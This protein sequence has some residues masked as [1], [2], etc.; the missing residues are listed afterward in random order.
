MFIGHTCTSDILSNIQS[1]WFGLISKGFIGILWSCR[2]L[3]HTYD[4]LFF[5]LLPASIFQCIN[6]ERAI[7]IVLR[8]FSVRM[9]ITRNLL[10]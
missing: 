6:A 3:N 1:A 10:L 2:K 4:V 9:P 5:F 8:L 7:L